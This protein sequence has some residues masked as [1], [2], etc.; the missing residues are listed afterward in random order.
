[1][2]LHSDP[3]KTSLFP[4][5]SLIYGLL[6]FQEFTG[7]SLYDIVNES[8]Q[9]PK[10]TSK[11][12]MELREFYNWLMNERAL[13]PNTAYVYVL[14]VKSQLSHYGINLK[15]K[16]LKRGERIEDWIP[17]LK[18]LWNMFSIGDLREKTIVSLAIDIPMRSNDFTKLKKEDVV[19]ILGAKEFPAFFIKKTSKNRLMPC[20]ISKE[21]ANILE[22]YVGTLRGDNPYLFQ[23]RGSESL[24]EDS[25]NR[26][27]KNL[28]VK[29]GIDTRGLRVRFQ[30]F[31]KLFLN[32]A[33][34]SVGLSIDQIKILLGKKVQGTLTPEYL[35]KEL[36]PCYEEVAEKLRPK[37]SEQVGDERISELEAKMQTLIKVLAK[38][39]RPI[40]AKMLLQMTP[41]FDKKNQ[42]NNHNLVSLTE[43]FVSDDKLEGLSTYDLLELYLKLTDTAT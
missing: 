8:R 24:S 36:K 26:I 13:S 37:D 22:K 33:R 38:L 31:R 20:F 7:K 42:D 34:D 23:G 39:I 10:S 41:N 16:G 40:L 4:N 35:L 43:R 29:L 25:L 11:L 21:T 32:V 9:D 3:K 5:K 2:S 17:S 15:I 27:V 1:V 28:V 12:E 14:A 18:E 30:M 19:P 6:L